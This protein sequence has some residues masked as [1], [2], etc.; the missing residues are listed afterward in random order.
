MAEF[1]KTRVMIEVEVSHQFD[2]MQGITIVTNILHPTINTAITASKVV[3]A[4]SN[5]VAYDQ[6]PSNEFLPVALCPKIDN[7]CHHWD[8]DKATDTVRCTHCGQERPVIS[9]DRSGGNG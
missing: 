5:Y 4:A 6:P 1:Y 8:M 7:G 9:N 2:P 3:S